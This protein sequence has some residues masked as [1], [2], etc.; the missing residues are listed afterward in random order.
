MGRF[1]KP[2]QALLLVLNPSV[3]EALGLFSRVHAAIEPD[4]PERTIAAK[5]FAQLRQ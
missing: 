2:R 3:D 4:Q 5:K 1:R